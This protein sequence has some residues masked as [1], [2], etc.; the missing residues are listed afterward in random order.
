MG[1]LSTRRRPLFPALV[2]TGDRVELCSW[3]QLFMVTAAAAELE[4]AEAG[5]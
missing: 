2:D 3:P 4:A 1:T 5:V